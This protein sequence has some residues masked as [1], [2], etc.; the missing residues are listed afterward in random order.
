MT[1]IAEVGSNASAQRQLRGAGLRERWHRRRVWL[2]LLRRDDDRHVGHGAAAA[3]DG[4]QQVRGGTEQGR[5][6]RNGHGSAWVGL[7][8]GS[9][10]SSHEGSDAG[11]DNEG[12]ETL[13]LLPQLLW[14]D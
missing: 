9:A 4:R 2:R 6:A 12:S 3:T 1:P 5:A 14:L 8:H 7:V 11:T 13:R 10:L